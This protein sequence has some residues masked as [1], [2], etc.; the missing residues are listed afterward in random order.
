MAAIGM[1]RGPS[2]DIQKLIDDKRYVWQHEVLLTFMAGLLGD[3][4]NAEF[5]GKPGVDTALECRTYIEKLTTKTD[6]LKL[7]TLVYESQQP[8]LV[9]IVPR[10]IHSAKV[11]F[12]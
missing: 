4:M 3:P 12:R 5:M 7:V 8:S 2:E 1:L 6:A 10:T 11:C 9:D